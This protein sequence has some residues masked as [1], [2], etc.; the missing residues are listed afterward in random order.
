MATESKT[1]SACGDSK[2]LDNFFKNKASS[3]GRYSQCR[4]C[5]KTEYQK[6]KEKV[7]VEHKAYYEKHKK[8]KLAYA[9][10]YRK[11]KMAENPNWRKLKGMA[12][13]TGKTFEEV[14]AWFN[15]QWMK[16]QAQCAI[17]GDVFCGNDHID[18]DHDTNEL[19]GLLC[20]LC[21]VGI[22]A[23]KDSPEVC[24]KAN[25]YLTEIERK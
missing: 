20:N 8:A 13:K 15:K 16:Q 7:S 12:Y 1:C 11:T 23:L 21:N 5:R 10:E 22:G 6:N 18:H 25:E 9:A 4:E 3:D 17:C 24:L 14:E 2:S 19:R